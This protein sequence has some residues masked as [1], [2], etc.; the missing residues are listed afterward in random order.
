MSLIAPLL[1]AL[2]TA[3][4]PAPKDVPIPPKAP[5]PAAEEAAP[6][7]Q[8][9]T[10]DNGDVIEEYRQEGRLYMVRVRPAHGKPYYFFDNNGDGLL[11]RADAE[12]T[13]GVAPVYWEIYTWD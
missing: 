4:A 7:V 11:D 9:R 12:H 13:G 1:L 8:I 5:P 6:T 3:Q 2:A 10:G